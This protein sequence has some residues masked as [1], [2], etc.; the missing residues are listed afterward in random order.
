MN[1][2]FENDITPEDR[3]L[4]NIFAHMMKI[5]NF[6]GNSNVEENH[7]EDMAAQNSDIRYIPVEAIP[8]F[9][10][11]DRDNLVL[12]G[13]P[14]EF[15][16]SYKLG[17]LRVISDRQVRPGISLSRYM[18]GNMVSVVRSYDD[19]PLGYFVDTVTPDNL[20]ERVEAVKAATDVK[21]YAYL[22]EMLLTL[23]GINPDDFGNALETIRLEDEKNKKKHFFEGVA[24]AIM[25]GPLSII[26]PGTILGAAAAMISE[27]DESQPSPKQ[28]A[29]ASLASD[30]SKFD[31]GSNDNLGHLLNNINPDDAVRLIRLMLDN[32]RKPARKVLDVENWPEAGKYHLHVVRRKLGNKDF[33]SNYKYC[34]YYSKGRGPKIPIKFVHTPSYCIYLMYVIDRAKRGSSAGPLN[35]WRN[36]D[37]FIDLY[38][39]LYGISKEDA[40]QKYI[41]ATYRKGEKENTVRGG[42]YNDYMTDIDTKIVE[43]LGDYDSFLLKPGFKGF[44]PIRPEN[45]EIDE[46]LKVF[47]FQ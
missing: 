19:R 47:N 12:I 23:A 29:S 3:F 7:S 5:T 11:G 36:K 38:M 27:P 10:L 26:A 32:P 2:D 6:D 9:P 34:L 37:A 17:N 28:K 16:N 18:G 44:L 46:N 24:G 40:V 43:K 1:M 33:G 20:L 13:H 22:H 39:A 42:R 41:I 25:D 14:S 15:G 45:I 35:L 30:A 21:W 4:H 31:K 8:G